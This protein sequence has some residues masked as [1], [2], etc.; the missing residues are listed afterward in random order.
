MPGSPRNQLAVPLTVTAL[1]L[2]EGQLTHVQ[3][4]RHGGL[5]W[6]LAIDDVVAAIESR[7]YSLGIRSGR[8][9]VVLV[10]RNDLARGF[11]ARDRSGRDLVLEL[12]VFTRDA[13]PPA[14]A[15]PIPTNQA[16]GP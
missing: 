4:S 2:S 11:E 14:L 12:P 3:G 8:E 16:T 13:P 9:R 15:S 6:R 7:R 10:R 5:P 1:E